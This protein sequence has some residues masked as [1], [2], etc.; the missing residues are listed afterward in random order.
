MTAEISFGF[1]VESPKA[2]PRK[3]KP[4]LAAAL[5]AASAST[6]GA[7]PTTTTTATATTTTDAVDLWCRRLTD[8]FRAVNV[9]VASELVQII[10]EY[11][12][13]VRKCLSGASACTFA[14]FTLSARLRCCFSQL[15]CGV[16]R[17]IRIVCRRMAQSRVRWVLKESRLLADLH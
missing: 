16:H 4:S 15:T 13:P 7:E 11:G 12:V 9:H 10:A 6:T 3:L 8:S 14:M 2:P 5:A 17:P 1:R